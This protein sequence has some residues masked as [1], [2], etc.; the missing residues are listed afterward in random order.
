MRVG[1]ARVAGN[2]SN[3]SCFIRLPEPEALAVSKPSLWTDP[4]RCMQACRSVCDFHGLERILGDE[5]AGVRLAS[6]QVCRRSSGFG[7]SA[8]NAGSMMTQPSQV[9]SV[10]LLSFVNTSAMVQERLALSFAVL[11][12]NSFLCYL[13]RN[14][15][16]LDYGFLH[17]DCSLTWWEGTCSRD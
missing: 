9:R 14:L 2:F 17:T 6:P 16:A 7:F 13:E 4:S 15:W 1:R 3:E 12:R 11:T 5:L 10:C 8:A